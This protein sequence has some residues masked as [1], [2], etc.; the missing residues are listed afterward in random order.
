MKLI[1]LLSICTLGLFLTAC[2]QNGDGDGKGA[3]GGKA[4]PGSDLKESVAHS[5]N[6]CPDMDGTYLAKI[7]GKTFRMTV[8]TSKFDNQMEVAADF[9][10]AD[11][12]E[13]VQSWRLTIDGKKY[14]YQGA[15]Y[16]GF[17]YKNQVFV[18]GI[19]NDKITGRTIL[20]KTGANILMTEIDENKKKNDTNWK[21]EN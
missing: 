1:Q 16:Q 13:R 12:N 4:V 2:A 9:D 20:S 18:D 17:C 15:F 19:A 6:D 14:E 5:L 7:Q 3:K 10:Q 21:K 8:T 11:T